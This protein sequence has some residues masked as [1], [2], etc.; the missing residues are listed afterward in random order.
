MKVEDQE[1]KPSW[2][3][4]NFK[5]SEATVGPFTGTKFNEEPESQVEGIQTPSAAKT[6]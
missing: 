5:A 6:L 1:F 4:F 3:L 2:L